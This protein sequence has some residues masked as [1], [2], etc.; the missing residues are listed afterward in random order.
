[1]INIEP[2]CEAV[3]KAYCKQRLKQGKSEYWT[4]GDYTKLNEVAK[5]YDRATVRAVLRYLVDNNITALK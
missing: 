4:K 5:D 2:I 1:M 3:H